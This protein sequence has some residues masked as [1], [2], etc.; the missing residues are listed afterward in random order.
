MK[1]LVFL[2]VFFFS[3]QFSIGQDMNFLIQQ[4]GFRDIKLG[5]NINS[6]NDFIK[7]DKSTEKYFSSLVGSRYEYM[8]IGKKYEKIDDTQIVSIYINTVNDLIYEIEII[9]EKDYK[10]WQFIE[11]AYGKPTVD[12]VDMKGWYPG[13]IRCRIT[14]NSDNF[15]Y[16][17]LKY[18]DVELED[19]AFIKKSETNKEKA[20]KQ[21]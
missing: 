14:G 6:Y 5:S 2:S 4:N 11:N 20:K 1:R 9:T 18:E 16:Y 7:K 10:L 15:S 8:Y 13:K 17:F 12:T 3:F 19:L 21:F